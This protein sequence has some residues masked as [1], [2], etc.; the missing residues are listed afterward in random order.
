MPL[1]VFVRRLALYWKRRWV[2][3]F[4]LLLVF[5]VAVA[6]EGYL[7]Y[8]PLPVE[9]S[10]DTKVK[11]PPVRSREELV[12]QDPL[13][14]SQTGLLFAHYGDE[15]ENLDIDLSDA[16][17]EMKSAQA[18]GIAKQAT[19][20]FGRITYRPKDLGEPSSS[21]VPCRTTLEVFLLDG[22]AN[23]KEMR[24]LA[25]TDPGTDM[26]R[27][28]RAKADVELKVVMSTDRISASSDRA[29]TSVDGPGCVK[30]LA[31]YGW[32]K[33]KSGLLRIHTQLAKQAELRLQ[34]TSMARETPL[35][36]GKDGLFE[37]FTS[38]SPIFKTRK[39]TIESNGVNSLEITS[40]NKNAL[41]VER[42]RVGSDHLIFEVSGKG[43]V[44]IDGEQ[45]SMN[46]FDRLKAY[47]FRSGLIL[48]ANAA[49]LTWLAREGKRLL[50]R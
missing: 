18:N 10:D 28:V 14:E 30:R 1:H 12:I 21:L 32:E 19:Q 15:L 9:V 2:R 11:L 29:G 16:R 39:V 38:A 25:A 36:N 49:L 23:P 3:A 24:F 6:V 4:V 33:V 46:L 8:M 26:Y 40:A 22:Q 31:G 20:Q 44:K 27:S 13:V 5:T 34:F 37:P 41:R 47:P 48:M 45:I 17:I 50:A 42:I 7:A 43:H 35:W